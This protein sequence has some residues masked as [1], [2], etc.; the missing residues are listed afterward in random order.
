MVALQS[1]QRHA[2]D[3]AHPDV[4]EEAGACDADRG[5]NGDDNHNSRMGSR[6][7]EQTTREC[8]YTD[9][10]KC[11][12]INFKGTE[13]VIGVALTCWKSHV[14][15]VG[16]DAAHGMS[17]NT[18]MKMMTAKYCPQNEIKKLGIEI[19]ELKVKG[20]TG[21]NNNNK[22]RDRTMAG[23]TL[24][25]LVRRNLT[26]D[27]NLCAPNATITMMDNM[28]PNATSATELA[29]WPVTVRVLQMPKPLTTKG[30]PG[31]VRKLLALSAEP[32]FDVIIGMDGLEK[33]QA[34]IVCVNKIIRI[35][36]GNKTFI[37]RAD[38]RDQGNETDLNII[39]CTKTQKYMLK[40]CH[41]FLEHVTTKKAEDKS[42]GKQLEDVP[43]VRDFPEVFLEDLPGLP[44]TQQVEF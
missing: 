25:G 38:G 14:K 21:T 32:N 40:G 18:L 1:Q 35:P 8:T 11:Q 29:I 3:P 28:L 37:V 20:T 42:K 34:I 5:R 4:P 23:I 10:L 7:T 31:Q 44:L 13:G 19:W 30:A 36:W 27:L 15:T 33:Y 26:D 22:T 2:R 6:R 39:S 41:V 12:P 24:L 17:W 16:Q 9:F 43:I